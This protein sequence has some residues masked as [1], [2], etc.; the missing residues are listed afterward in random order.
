M[1]SIS[2]TYALLDPVMTVLRPLA[3]LV[4]SVFAGT[5]IDAVQKSGQTEPASTGSDPSEAFCSSCATE[6]RAKP[7]RHRLYQGLSYAFGD[8]LGDIGK[9]FLAGVLAAGTISA[10]VPSAFIAEHLGEGFLPMLIMLAVGVPMYVCATATTPIAAALALKGLSPGAALVFLLAGP[11]TNIASLTVISG[12]LG[13]R[14][15]GIY[16]GSIA[17][18]SLLMGVA[19]NYLYGLLGM[20]ITGWAARGGGEHGGL[21]QHLLAGI[22]T[23]LILKAILQNIIAS[24]SRDRGCRC[25]HGVNQ[26]HESC[27]G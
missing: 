7:L 17:A 21:F 16:L 25:T 14:A 1:D 15:T 8:L 5:C 18:C 12:I 19:A 11:A 27:C 24:R 23:A 6:V 9:W 2:V 22:L 20:D 4:T 10:L 13:K 26:S 3:A